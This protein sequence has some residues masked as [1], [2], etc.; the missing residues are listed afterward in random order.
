MTRMRNSLL[1]ALAGV[2]GLAGTLHASGRES[3][4][5][6][7]K[8]ATVRVTNRGPGLVNVSLQQK[9][10]KTGRIVLGMVPGHETAVLEIPNG[11]DGARGAR[12]LV[13]PVDYGDFKLQ[14]LSFK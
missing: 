14:P 1:I 10:D 9:G 12:V 13:E 5:R 3:T 11:L 4:K 7:P 6:A 8:P 2:A